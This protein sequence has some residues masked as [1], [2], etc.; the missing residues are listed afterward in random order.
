MVPNSSTL[1]LSASFDQIHWSFKVR[2]IGDLLY[3]PF[4]DLIDLPSPWMD[5]GL[6]GSALGYWVKMGS[7]AGFIR[8]MKSNFPA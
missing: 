8:G 3:Q 1:I 4:W 5:S 6:L 7:S 2:W